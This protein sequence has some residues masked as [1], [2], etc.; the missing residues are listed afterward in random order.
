MPSTG[1][2]QWEVLTIA[3][4]C[5]SGINI[6]NAL[7]SYFSRQ[8]LMQTLMNLIQVFN[9]TN[10][11]ATIQ[12]LA[13]IKGVTKKMDF[14]P[15]DIGMGKLKDT[16]LHDV[17]TASKEGTLMYFWFHLLHIEHYWNI[18]YASDTLN[19]YTHLAQGEH[20]SIAQYLTWDKVLLECIHQYSKM[21]NL[22]G[23]GYNKL[24]LVRGVC[25]PH[26]Q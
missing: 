2:Y 4:C 11:E 5:T 7:D 23:I 9:G 18:P 25:S 1:K 6:G 3:S 16:A 20:E 21:C 10:P 12:W 19:T 26:A 15:V 13:H 22:T 24:H 14:D 8:F 17:N